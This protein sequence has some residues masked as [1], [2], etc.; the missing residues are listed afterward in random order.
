VILISL[1]ADHVC[2]HY[3]S[4]GFTKDLDAQATIETDGEILA[5]PRKARR[6]STMG[7]D[8]SRSESR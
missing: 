4:F 3:S 6:R 1:T 2:A 7:E 8:V 5:A